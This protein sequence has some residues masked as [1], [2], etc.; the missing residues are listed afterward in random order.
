[1][2]RIRLHPAA[3]RSRQG[4]RQLWLIERRRLRSLCRIDENKRHSTRPV[5]A[6]PETPILHPGGP[7]NPVIHQQI[8][9]VPHELLCPRVI[10][11]RKLPAL[12]RSTGSKTAPQY[13]PRNHKQPLTHKH[14]PTSDVHTSV[15]VYGCCLVYR[16]PHP[17]RSLRLPAMAP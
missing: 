9:V 8:H 3:R 12:R 15:Q 10:L 7:R 1:M 6:V 13:S 16:S 11:S 17:S 2:I 14:S 4:R 5:V